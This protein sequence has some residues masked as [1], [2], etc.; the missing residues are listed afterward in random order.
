MPMTRRD[1]LALLLASVPAALLAGCGGGGGDSGNGQTNHSRSR[2]IALG[3]SYAYGYSTQPGTPTGLGDIGYVKLFAN[4]LAASNGGVRPEVLNLAIP[5]ETTTTFL[6]PGNGTPALPYNQNYAATGSPSQFSLLEQHTYL[7]PAE[8]S[9]RWV[10]LQIGG[11]DLLHLLVDPAFRAADSD[12]RQALIAATL[13]TFSAN[14]RVILARMARIRSLTPS[15]RL[16]VL[17]YPDPF[18][19]LGI[20]NP[21]SGLSTPLAQQVN[22][23]I[24][25]AASEV[26]AIYVDVFT[27]FVGH[28][29]ALSLI[30][31]TQDPP[32]SGIPDFHPSAAGYAK[33]AELLVAANQ[34]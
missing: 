13:E 17:G 15:V 10:T 22:S 16:F 32:G 31:T 26:S 21:L 7:L 5:G 25:K 33:I 9:I 2:Y 30:T 19:G 27:P 8:E 6:R 29:A 4:V 23:V 18:E 28:E 1:A 3:D 14:L 11:D 24:S 20:A 34:Q 12:E